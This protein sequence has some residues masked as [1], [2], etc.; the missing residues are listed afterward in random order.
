VTN[1]NTLLVP[2]GVAALG[3]VLYTL[4]ARGRRGGEPAPAARARAVATA[5]APAPPPAPPASRNVT[6]AADT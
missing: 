6:P 5:S 1:H 3:I 2:F 4:F